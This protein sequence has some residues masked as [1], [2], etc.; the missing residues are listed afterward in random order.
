M[1]VINRNSRLCCVVFIVIFCFVFIFIPVPFTVALY[2][3][4]PITEEEYKHKSI[5][6]N[7]LS[8]S[9]NLNSSNYFAKNSTKGRIAMAMVVIV[10]AYTYI[11]VYVCKWY[12][13]NSRIISCNN[14][15]R[16]KV[17]NKN[18]YTRNLTGVWFCFAL[19][20][21]LL[22]VHYPK[23]KRPKPFIGFA[24]AF[25]II[26]LGLDSLDGQDSVTGL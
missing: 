15:N 13:R 23:A 2:S 16:R 4:L 25:E 8:K 24:I 14:N 7:F 26:S 20:L 11:C 10:A 22:I 18:Y 12:M 17:A 1:I 5:N 19:F 3:R 9:Y 6:Y 21:F